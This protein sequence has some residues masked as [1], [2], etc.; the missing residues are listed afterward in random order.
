MKMFYLIYRQGVA[1]V[2]QPVPHLASKNLPQAVTELKF[3]ILPKFTG[4]P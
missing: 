4:M 3:I 1:I 2:A